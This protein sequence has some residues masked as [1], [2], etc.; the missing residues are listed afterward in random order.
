MRKSL[1]ETNEFIE[2]INNGFAD[3]QGHLRVFYK[4]TD[5]EGMVFRNTGDIR[6][7][8]ETANKFLGASDL[9]QSYFLFALGCSL[10]GL[11]FG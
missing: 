3:R 7:L 8:I 10:H 1:Q 5:R 6:F 2:A 4:W 9:K 11:W